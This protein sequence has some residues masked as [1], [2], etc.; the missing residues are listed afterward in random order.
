MN[1]KNLSHALRATIEMKRA[2]VS[3]LESA[4]DI[5]EGTEVATCD[6]A[7]EAP[8]YGQVF[9]R[10]C[11]E[12]SAVNTRCDRHGGARAATYRRTHCEHGEHVTITPVVVRDVDI[13]SHGGRKRGEHTYQTAKRQRLAE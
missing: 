2:E 4:L 13:A 9:T 1:D 12:C 10:F 5:V 7:D 6:N 8:C 3:S 11:T